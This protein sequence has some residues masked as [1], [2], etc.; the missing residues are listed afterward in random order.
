MM[1]DGGYVLFLCV[2]IAIGAVSYIPSV[3]RRANENFIFFATGLLLIF[4]S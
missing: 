2:V 4:H 3:G 1:V